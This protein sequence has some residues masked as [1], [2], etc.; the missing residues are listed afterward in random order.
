[1]WLTVDWQ[2]VGVVRRYTTPAYLQNAGCHHGR[3]HVFELNVSRFVHFNTLEIVCDHWHRAGFESVIGGASKDLLLSSTLRY[4]GFPE[5]VK[6][7]LY[8][9]YCIL[10]I[11]FSSLLFS[12]FCFFHILL[13]ISHSRQELYRR[14]FPF[15]RM[16]KKLLQPPEYDVY[17][18]KIDFGKR[19]SR[20]R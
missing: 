8:N 20:V 4:V 16:T 7:R 19:L 2:G 12:C 18:F 9:F 14:P 3:Y 6:P 1:M 13:W 5:V 15:P 10:F 11:Q 17:T